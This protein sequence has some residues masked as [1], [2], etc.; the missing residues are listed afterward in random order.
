MHGRIF[1]VIFIVFSLIQALTVQASADTCSATS[2]K[3]RVALLELYTSEGCSSC[4]PADEYLSRLDD[5]GI[6]PDRLVPLSL[7]VDYWN[8]IGWRDPFSSAEYTQRQREVGRR[9]HL[10]SI[11]TPQMVLNGRDFRSWRR[12]NIGRAIN[13]L[14]G[15]PGAK[16]VLSW[17]QGEAAGQGSL[18]VKVDV[19]LAKD[20]SADNAIF[21]LVVFENKIVSQINAGENSGRSL[22]HDYVVRKLLKI[23]FTGHNGHLQ[24]TLLVPLARDWNLSELGLAA[25]VQN[26]RTGDIL[27]AMS[28]Q[29][30]CHS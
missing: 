22:K 16:I 30:G 17:Q 18:S 6:G 19:T 9:N 1:R 2:P 27:Q 11:Y 5:I 13:K 8:Y 4:P 12:L 29:I 15:T 24:Q 3:Q 7:H 14:S 28:S 25:F 21:H 20:E 26:T 10:A 23:P